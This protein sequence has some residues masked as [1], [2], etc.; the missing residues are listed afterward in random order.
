MPWA[1]SKLN[2]I[3]L[4]TVPETPRNQEVPGNQEVPAGTRQRRGGA[5]GTRPAADDDRSAASREALLAAARELFTT[6]GYAATNMTDIVAKAGTS[7]GLPYYYFGSKRKIF[8]TLWSDYQAKQEARTRLAITS[9]RAAGETD[10]GRLLVLGMRAYLEGAWEARDLIPMMNGHDRPSGFDS[11]VEETNRRWAK[12]NSALLASEDPVIARAANVILLSSIGGMSVELAGCHA[13]AKARTLIER[14]V[15]L[16][17]AV[18]E[19]A[20]VKAATSA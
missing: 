17:T 9:A 2:E 16:W 6:R 13:E 18:I 8:V 14:A 12:R 20:Q 4:R 19:R 5:K 3:K 1:A 7:V 15:E 11:V 10:G